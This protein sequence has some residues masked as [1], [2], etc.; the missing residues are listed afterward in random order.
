METQSSRPKKTDIVRK[1]TGCQNCK[2]R[3]RKCDETRPDCSACVRRGIKCSGYDRPVAF[4][5]VT[6]LAA[7]SSRKFEA[8]R[9]SALRH[10]DARRKRRM[11]AT[12]TAS[13]EVV[14]PDIIIGP[15]LSAQAPSAPVPAPSTNFMSTEAWSGGAFALPWGLFDIP[16][17]A[18]SQVFPE[19]AP[20]LGTVIESLSTPL[21]GRASDDTTSPRQSSPEALTPANWDEFL[22]SQDSPLDTS[23]AEE[24][25]LGEP[26]TDLQISLPLEESLV[27]HFDT[28]VIPAI[29][30]ALAFS[31]LF[32]SSS[33]FRAAV[34]ALSASH[35]KLAERLPMDFQSLRRICDD[36]CVWVYYDTA[37][38]DLQLQ[39]QR[40]N[41]SSEELAGAA[42]LLAYHEL[43]A[44][45]A[46]GLRNHASGLD[47]IASKMDFAASS[48]PNL[49]KAWRMLRYDIRYTY[50]PTRKSSNPVDNY[51]SASFLDPQLAIRDVMSRVFS[52]YS[53][54]AMEASFLNDNTV[55]GSSASERA[56]RWLCS[57]LNRK[58][59]HRNFQ[60]GD[61]YK[62]DL[63]SEKVLEQCDTFSKH[64]DSWH[65]GLRDCDL[66]IVRVGADGDTITGPTFE[67][68]I[69]YRFTDNTKAMDYLLY[70][71][72]RMS[73]SNLR[74]VYDPS[75]S[76]AATEAWGKV[77]LGIICGMNVLQKQQFTV[78]RIDV[79]V[80]WVALLVESTNF[81]RTILDYLIPKVLSNGLTAPEMVSWVYTKARMEYWLREKLQIDTKTPA[82]EASSDDKILTPSTSNSASVADIEEPVRG[83]IS[84]S[85]IQSVVRDSSQ[86]LDPGPVQRALWAICPPN[87]TIPPPPI[88]KK[89]NTDSAEAKEDVLG[90]YKELSSRVD[91]LEQ[92]NRQLQTRFVTEQTLKTRTTLSLQA[93]EKELCMVQ[94]AFWKLWEAHRR[95]LI[96]GLE[97]N[98]M[99][100]LSWGANDAG[101]YL[102][103]LDHGKYS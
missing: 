17:N 59:D 3:R 27:Q 15:A 75:V 23:S 39:I 89:D 18:P 38:K 22:V 57:V 65:K 97:A 78:L 45:T 68:V 73:I 2:T 98:G 13:S 95:Q 72:S 88:T 14:R 29:P 46:F 7:E 40:S 96:S 9:W 8:A 83:P 79:L 32:Q 76:A 85:S 66:P 37:V 101:I 21:P 4:K 31:N 42:L 91:R 53:R 64:L 33:C 93:K 34:L 41:K 52:L 69:T 100:G 61:F 26:T 54:N 90:K 77:A 10:E 1:R 82:S 71:I 103:S 49:F 6:A 67:P 12:D 55:E 74:S 56:A 20:V 44:G 86:S 63:T 25:L 94:E 51:D 70:L 35:L 81:A 5:D 58:S 30:V 92:E 16:N 43:E 60:R 87:S 62:E 36:K 19:V 11:T 80:R 48:M 99:E 84:T 50:T 102:C 24:S 28:N 47:A